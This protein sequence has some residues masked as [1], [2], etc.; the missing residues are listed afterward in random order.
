MAEINCGVW[1]TPANFNEFRVFA[2][3]LHLRHST[4]VN[5]TLHDFGLSWAG[6]LYM[7]FWGLLSL[8]E[9]FQV[10]NLLCLQVLRYPILATLLYGTRAVG[11]SR[12]LRRGT[13][14]QLWN[15]RRRRHQ[16][17][18]ER[19]SRWASTHILVIGRPFVKRFALCYRSVIC[20]SCPVLSCLSCLS[21]SDVGVLL[22][23]GW[24]DRDKTWRAGRPRPWPHCVKW[25]PTSPPLKGTSPIFGPYLLR[26]NG[27]MD[28]DAT[29]HIARPQ[30]R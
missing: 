13:R 4:E 26:P 9:F 3:L 21:V 15:F 7:H 22:P 2:S 17:S 6:I 25:G 14:M 12:T 11:V 27:F 20:L 8:T 29:Q 5:Q 1:G 16:Y 24:T 23:N 18:A 10:Q 28:Q 19:P 30:P